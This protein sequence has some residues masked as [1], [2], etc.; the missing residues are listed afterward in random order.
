MDL[1]GISGYES[2][3]NEDG[4]SPRKVQNDSVEESKTFMALRRF[5]QLPMFKWLLRIINLET[6]F[7]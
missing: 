3:D 2:D 7:G 1:F 4:T 6:H 5:L